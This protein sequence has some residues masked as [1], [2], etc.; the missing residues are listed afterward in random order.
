MSGKMA[1][2]TVAVAVVLLGFLFAGCERGYRQIVVVDGTNAEFVTIG[3]APADTQGFWAPGR[4]LVF[5]TSSAVPGATNGAKGVAG[6]VYRVKDSSVMEDLGEF[7][8]TLPN[9]T[10]CYRYGRD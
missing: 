2:A 1:R 3:K 10:L 5:R 7:D 4:V 8:L 6:R 9:D